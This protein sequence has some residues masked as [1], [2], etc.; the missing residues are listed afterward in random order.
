MVHHAD[1]M[2]AVKCV[3]GSLKKKKKRNS[4]K[5]LSLWNRS[6]YTMICER[7]LANVQDDTITFC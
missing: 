5:R 4:G 7:V 3:N 6:R 1:D 2:S